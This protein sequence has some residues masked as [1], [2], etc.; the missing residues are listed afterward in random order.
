MYDKEPQV[1]TVNKNDAQYLDHFQINKAKYWFQKFIGKILF[2]F[3]SVIIQLSFFHPLRY[4][5]Q[6]LHIL[7]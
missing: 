6:W 2:S 5:Q 7:E 4:L 3:F 1:F